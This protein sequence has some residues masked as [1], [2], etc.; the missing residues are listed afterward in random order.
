MTD[1]DGNSLW[2]ATEKLW[3]DLY[4]NR[5]EVPGLSVKYKVTYDDEWLAEAYMETDYSTLEEDDFQTTINSY[6]SYLVKEG[7]VYES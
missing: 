3:L 4:R 7:E 5:K 2:T 1:S 6:L